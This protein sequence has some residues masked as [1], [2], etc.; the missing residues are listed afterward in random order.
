[1]ASAPRIFIVHPVLSTQPTETQWVSIAT[2]SGSRGPNWSNRT[3]FLN[4]RRINPWIGL[5]LV[6]FTGPGARGANPWTTGIYSHFETNMAET[7]GSGAEGRR[8]EMRNQSL[9]CARFETN[10]Q[11]SPNFSGNW[12]DSVYKEIPV[13]CAEE[14]SVAPGTAGAPGWR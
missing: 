1:M 3:L 5:G 6:L 9:E 11:L 10:A 13:L 12:R 8:V 2:P 14:R 4:M 7:G